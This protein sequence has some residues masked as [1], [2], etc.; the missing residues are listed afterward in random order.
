MK[1]LYGAG[2][3]ASQQVKQDTYSDIDTTLDE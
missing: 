3:I 1:S 2:H